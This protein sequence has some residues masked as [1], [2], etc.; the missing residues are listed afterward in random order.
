MTKTR[1]HAVSSK[2]QGIFDNIVRDREI[3]HEN[4]VKMIHG[5]RKLRFMRNKKQA[6]K[7]MQRVIGKNMLSLPLAFRHV[8][9]V[10]GA[11]AKNRP[12]PHILM[13]D[14]ADIETQ[15]RGQQ[16]LDL[17]WQNLERLAKKKLYWAWADNVVADGLGVFKFTRHPWADFPE[18]L[19]DESG[20]P[21]ESDAEYAKR[22]DTFFNSKP[23]IPFRMKTVQPHTVFFPQHEWEMKDIV[24]I[25]HRNLRETLRSLRVV[26][27]ASLKSFKILGENEPY[28]RDEIPAIPGGNV[29]VYEIWTEDHVAFGMMGEWFEMENPYGGIIPYVLTGGATT[30]SNDPTLE[31][32]SAL[33]PFQRTQPWA[34]M[35]LSSLVSWSVLASNPIV[36]TSRDATAGMTA[37]DETAIEEIPWGKHMDLGV[38]GNIGVVQ[39]P[40]SGPS[41]KA[42]IELM[43]DLMDRSALSPAASGF[44]GTRTAGLAIASAVEQSTAMLSGTLDNMQTGISEVYKMMMQFVKIGKGPVYASGFQFESGKGNRKEA[45]IAKWDPDDVDKVLDVLAEIKSEGLQELISKG[46]HA[47]FMR[48]KGIWSDERSMLFSGVEDVERERINILKDM[49][50]KH[51]LVLQ[52][53]A[54]QATA[55]EPPL[56]A[57]FQQAIEAA[58]EGGGQAPGNGQ[59]PTSGGGE[60]GQG[61]ND[62]V[63]APPQRGGR[64]SGSPSALPKGPNQGNPQAGRR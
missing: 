16:W 10:V 50:R 49:A 7:Q 45:G 5:L 12:T 24:E 40:D 26:P 28:P 63:G 14:V 55:E 20:S 27:S 42:S 52:Y 43:V 59:Q 19:V 37:Q 61:G 51:P 25:N 60:G 34:D 36:W 2:R 57:L 30:G 9:T 32:I 38:G 4:R 41:I 23:P 46:T 33:Y 44:M 56:A 13:R 53:L 48:D 35:M 6:P 31:H 15:A 58:A 17:V 54:Q 64:P 62:P 22:V 1:I 8:Q 21:T 47:A 18:I 3:T 39:I 11:I 29:K